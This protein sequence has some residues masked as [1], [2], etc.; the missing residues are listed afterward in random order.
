MTDKERLEGMVEY[1]ESLPI[2]TKVIVFEPG[3][4]KT[5]QMAADQLGVSV[6]QI[7]KSILFLAEET[8][9]LVVTSGDAK[10]NTSKIKKQLGIKPKMASKEE[11]IEKT[12]F[13][14][15]G[16]CPFGL[17]NVQILL[18]SSM[19]RFDTVYAAAGTSNTAVPITMAQ[20]VEVTGGKVVDVCKYGKE[21]SDV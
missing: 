4:T 10:I 5:A 3:T 17:T 1:I 11:C 2:K 20:L 14:P 12:G 19:E 8:P 21:L 18:D 6:G 7:A 9:V 16:V 15:G 13:P